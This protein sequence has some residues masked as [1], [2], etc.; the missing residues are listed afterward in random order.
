MEY[1]IR[2]HKEADN[3]WWAEVDE[4]TGCFATGQDLTEALANLAESI[5]LYLKLTHE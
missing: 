1:T 4:L 2:L 3:T 5:S